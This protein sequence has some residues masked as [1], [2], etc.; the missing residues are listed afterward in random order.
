MILQETPLKNS[1]DKFRKESF[2][3]QSGGDKIWE[4]VKICVKK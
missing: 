3:S 4:T 2:I 1:L